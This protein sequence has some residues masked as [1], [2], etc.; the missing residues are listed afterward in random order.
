MAARPNGSNWRLLAFLAA[1]LAALATA[2]GFF[3]TPEG[4]ASRGDDAIANGI[5]AN[6]RLDPAAW[7]DDSLTIAT[8]GHATLLMNFM[9]VRVITDPTL[10]NRIGLAVG[11]LFTIGPRRLTPPPL[12]PNQIGRIDVILVTHA[13]MDHLDLPSLDALPKTAAVVACSGCAALIRPLGFADVREL[14][15]GESTDVRGL[16]V[17]ALPARHWGR[18]WPPFGRSYGYNSYLIVRHRRRML[19]AC[20]TAYTNALDVVR[21]NPPEVAA[22]SIGA[23]DP[24]IWNHADPEQVWKMFA[25]TGARFLIPIHW[26][27]FRLSKEPVNEPMR[28]LLSAAGTHDDQIVLRQIGEAWTLPRTFPAVTARRSVP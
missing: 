8:L 13:H 22:F 5:M 19:L 28:R 21:G 7:R 16:T 2:F 23:Y 24:W 18:R 11:P 12:R 15:W 25:A 27:T 3:I 6:D 1:A 26:G 10:F 9:G 20:D 14:K 17:T 4:A